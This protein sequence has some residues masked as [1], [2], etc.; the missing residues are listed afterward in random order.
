[1]SEFGMIIGE[2]G[3][4]ILDTN[5]MV[6]GVI[7]S[8]ITTA[9]GT[10]NYIS[11][12][13]YYYGMSLA[14]TIG[15]IAIK[16]TYSGY[17]FVFKN[18]IRSTIQDSIE[19]IVYGPNVNSDR[20]IPQ[21]GLVIYDADGNVVYNSNNKY[22]KIVEIIN[23]SYSVITRPGFIET[24]I[25][26]NT[27]NPFYIMPINYYIIPY[28]ATPLLAGVS[29][30]CLGLKM[31]SPTSVSIRRIEEHRT[32]PVT[33]QPGPPPKLNVPNPFRIALCVP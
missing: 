7:T 13:R 11:Q 27:A 23:V 20:P 10:I 3:N 32:G 17:S 14:E 1:M 9:W 2:N 12:A 18:A 29:Y 19:Y 16:P 6:L 8:G 30:S 26:H 21:Y 22:M 31:L 28:N 4:I 15:A 25:Y 5:K 24:T 33:A